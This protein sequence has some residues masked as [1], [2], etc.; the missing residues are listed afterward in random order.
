V[1]HEF[2]QSLGACA[3]FAH[4]RFS[5]GQ[6]RRGHCGNQSLEGVGGVLLGFAF[7]FQ[8]TDEMPETLGIVPLN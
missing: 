4:V 1:E 2:T 8:Q 3:A 7:A 5:F 6:L